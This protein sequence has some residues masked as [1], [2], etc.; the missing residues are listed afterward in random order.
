LSREYLG[1]LKNPS[2]DHGEK[3]DEIKDFGFP[4]SSPEW[5]KEKKDIPHRSPQVFQFPGT[6][7]RHTHCPI[8]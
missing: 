8:K 3:A 6:T 2:Q 7:L 4:R 5:K 1:K